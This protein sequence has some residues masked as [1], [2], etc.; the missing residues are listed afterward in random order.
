MGAGA[1]GRT[2]N[3]PRGVV[4]PVF[5]DRTHTQPHR[6]G[7]SDLNYAAAPR[8]H[9]V[10]LKPPGN[11]KKIIKMLKTKRPWWKTHQSESE[12]L[13]L[14]FI[15]SI[16]CPAIATA[17][18]ADPV[19]CTL[20]PGKCGV[21]REVVVVLRLAYHPGAQCRIRVDPVAAHPAFLFH[22]HPTAPIKASL[23]RQQ[24]PPRQAH[25]GPLL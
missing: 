20:T 22:H 1:S 6:G 2:A 23:R 7:P 16:G 13:F 18:V 10:L 25:L 5:L 11:G 8:S 3:L 15:F 24:R 17:L 4:R 9:A 21:D 19:P 14:T 12:V